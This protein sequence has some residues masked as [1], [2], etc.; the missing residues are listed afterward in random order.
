MKSYSG[1]W[2]G[3]TMGRS[4]RLYSNSRWLDPLE[5]PV[6]GG[7][8][9]HHPDVEKVGPAENQARGRFSGVLVVLP[10]FVHPSRLDCGWGTLEREFAHVEEDAFGFRCYW[11]L[12]ASQFPFTQLRRMPLAAGALRQR[13]RDFRT[14]TKRA[15]NSD[16]GAKA[17][18]GS[19][20]RLIELARG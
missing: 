10:V 3:G 12:T 2:L 14:T 16:I 13:G 18:G 19:T 6:C 17:N 20:K 8:H 4:T 1:R 5:C 9:G 15:G 7:G 11:S